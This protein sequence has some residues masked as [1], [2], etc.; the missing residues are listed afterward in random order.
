[1]H[2]A[3]RGARR[4]H[5]AAQVVRA[6][7]VKLPGDA[8]YAPIK[9]GRGRQPIATTMA[10]VRLL[11][12]LMRDP[13]DRQAL[14]ADRPGRGPH[15]RHGLAVPDR[16]DLQPARAELRGRGPR[17]AAV[18]QGVAERPDAARGHLRGGLH[19]VADRR[20]LVVLD[21][22]RADDPAL[23]LLL[24]VRVPAHRRP[25]LADGRPAGARLRAGRHRR[26]HDADRRGAAARRRA[27]AP[28]GL[29]EPGG[30][31]ATTRRSRFE[32]AHIV[33]DGLRRMYGVGR[34]APARRGRLLLPA[35]STTSRSSQPAE[36]EDVDVEGM[37]KGLYRL[38]RG[39]TPQAT[40]PRAPDPGVRRRPSA[41]RSRR[42]ACSPRSGASPPTSGPATSWNELR[43][44]AVACEEHNLLHP[45]RS[46]GSRTSRASWTARRARSWRS[47]RL[48]A[49]GA[50][51][52]RP[53][54][55]GRTTQSLGH[56]RLRLR[57]HPRRGAALLPR[58][59]RVDRG[60]RALPSCAR[61][62]EVDAA[63]VKKAIDRYQ[64]LDVAGAS[65]SARSA[66]TRSADR[67]RTKTQ[68]ADAPYKRRPRMRFRLKRRRARTH[69]F[70]ASGRSALCRSVRTGAGPLERY[71]QF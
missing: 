13:G 48:D 3:P 38:T 42:S 53:L 68:T 55:A 15:V 49:V 23:H 12:D 47:T 9:K 4:L 6:K 20:R 64:I 52:D 71:T 61:R 40:A 2:G 63:T 30:R 8:V 10:F 45:G 56:R 27:L 33:E 62:G 46:R 1:M 59:R 37:L 67:R 16:E 22:R 36:P 70:R 57:R 54:G 66:A 35:P 28:A 50:R 31:G 5:A 44:E 14:R 19:G 69:R 25:V 58:R 51:P 39:A 29:D 41:G 34:P 65:E 26:A 17:A 21:A 32:I 7:P 43:R 24:D 11:K 18:L 60:R